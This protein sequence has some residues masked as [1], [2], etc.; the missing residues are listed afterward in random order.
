MIP[1]YIF[2][3]LLILCV[4]AENA[5]SS[6]KSKKLIFTLAL[7]PYFILLAFKSPIVGAD[8]MNYFRSF[9]A[10][11]SYGF[12]DF[13][14]FSE[15]GYE[16][17]EKGYILYIWLLSRISSDGQ[18]LLIATTLINTTAIY[19]FIKRNAKKY[20]LALFFLVTLG[21]FQFAMSGIRQTLAISIVLFGYGF[22]RDRKLI[23]FS[24]V[25]VVAML[26]HKS[27]IFFFPAY[28]VAGMKLNRM[29][30]GLALVSTVVIY[31][32]T[33]DALLTAADVLEYDYGIESTGN[34]Y[35]FFVAVL[36]I[37]L[38]SII[39]RKRLIMANEDNSIPIKLN[40]ISLAIWTM[41]LVSRTAERITLYYMPYTY[42]TLE[43]F[44]LTRKKE[45]RSILLIGTILLCS[46]LCL[47]RLNLQEDLNNYIFF[48]EVSTW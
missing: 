16:R 37:T 34:G 7:F 39:N 36:L 43:Q 10:M 14:N 23:K 42:I 38:L 18:I 26:F 35:I 4:F 45:E 6:T 27:A 2:I 3:L 24:I 30:I 29:N 25:V 44:I 47:R 15:F 12:S 28:F 46:Y 5:S 32:V 33:G 41:R 22:L 19:Y 9:A 40:L 17:I 48:I 8:T 31:F 21:F 1:Y 11:S 20:C 13:Y